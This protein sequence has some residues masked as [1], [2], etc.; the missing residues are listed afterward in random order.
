MPATS[1][2]FGH[3]GS[4][5]AR[6]AGSSRPPITACWPTG[7]MRVKGVASKGVRLGNWL[8]SRQTQTLLNT[9]DA[10]ATKGLRDRAIPALLLGCGLR[11]SEVAALTMSHIQQRGGRWCIVDIVGR[12]SGVRTVPCRPGQSSDRRLECHGG[13][14]R[15]SRVP[16]GEPRRH[17]RRA[18]AKRSCGSQCKDTLRQPACQALPPRPSAY[19]EFRIMPRRCL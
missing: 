13:Y 7:I 10:T 17:S 15:R 18:S 14:C 12:H 5:D 19:A 2:T 4:A 1:Q 6:L 8:S 16:S 11:R 9:P 3:R